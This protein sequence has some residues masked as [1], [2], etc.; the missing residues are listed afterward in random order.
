MSTV[1]VNPGL[2]NQVLLALERNTLFKKEWISYEIQDDFQLLLIS[3]SID[4]LTAQGSSS[5]F[6]DAGLL[7]NG[8]VPS[9]PDDYSWML[10]F[11]KAGKVEDSYFGGNSNSPNSGL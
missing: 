7:V 3:I 9:R 8:M 11:T 1:P 10:A 4:E 2:I 6:K 5:I